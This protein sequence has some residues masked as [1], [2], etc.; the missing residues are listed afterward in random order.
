MTEPTHA[1]LPGARAQRTKDARSHPWKR[2]CRNAVS[3]QVSPL[4]LVQS[5]QNLSPR[6]TC[7]TLH[8]SAAFP[9]IFK[10][11]CLRGDSKKPRKERQGGGGRAFPQPAAPANCGGRT[12]E[13]FL[14]GT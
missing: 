8:T 4:A 5:G 10:C 9:L 7:L 2:S 6:V 13:R 11:T 1:F 12:R 3:L 14:G